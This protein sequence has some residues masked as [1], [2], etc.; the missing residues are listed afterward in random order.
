M[1]KEVPFADALSAI[2]RHEKILQRDFRRALEKKHRVRLIPGS[3]QFGVDVICHNTIT[4][5][6]TKANTTYDDSIRKIRRTCLKELLD[7]VYDALNT[8]PNHNVVVSVPGFRPGSFN[9]YNVFATVD[10]SYERRIAG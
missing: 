2:K 4:R 3:C 6:F 1:N 8:W 7:V 9:Q 10:I 5:D